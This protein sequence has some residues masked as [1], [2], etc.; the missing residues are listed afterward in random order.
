[1]FSLICT[2]TKCWVNNWDTGDLRCHRAHYDVTVMIISIAYVEEVMHYYSTRGKRFPCCWPTVR[3]IHKIPC[4]RSQR[5]GNFMLPLLLLNK[6]LNKL[7]WCWWLRRHD[8]NVALLNWIWI[9]FCLL[10]IDEI[11]IHISIEIKPNTPSSMLW[12]YTYIC[13]GIPISI[14]DNINGLA[15]DFCNSIANELE[16]LQSCAKP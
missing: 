10:V 2:W 9:I 5:C 8:A 1:M 16:L 3:W 13:K 12:I 14:N 7:P 6:L 11:Y 15:Q 4:T